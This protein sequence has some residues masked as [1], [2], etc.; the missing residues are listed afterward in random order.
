M[1]ALLA[2]LAVAIALL[3]S[4]I[5]VFIDEE[6]AV[7]YFE[8]IDGPEGELRLGL[9]VEAADP[10]N[11]VSGT[12]AFP[13]D[14][15]TVVASKPYDSFVDVWLTEPTVDLKKGEIHFAGGSSSKTGLTERG[16]ILE[17]TIASSS[18]MYA[19]LQLKDL[20]T[21]GRDGKGTALKTGG[22]TFIVTGPVEP[23][24]T[25]GGGTYNVARHEELTARSDFNEDGAVSLGDMS[26]LLLNILSPYDVHYDLNS[27]GSVGL[28]DFSALITVFGASSKR[29]SEPKEIDTVPAQKTE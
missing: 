9:Y 12:I 15:L 16:K 5:T 29:V 21:F 23:V 13:A 25:G 8:K 27:D 6:S 26:I 28:G 19:D 1:Q 4:T 11:V 3:A 10:I 24:A 22:R 20:E 2:G 7:V 14:R 18:E 17:L